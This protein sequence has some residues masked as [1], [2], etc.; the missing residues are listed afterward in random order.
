L[1][2]II[3]LTRLAAKDKPKIMREADICRELR[4]PNI[5]LLEETFID[6]KARLG[7]SRDV[8]DSLC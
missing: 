4:H 3:D 2:Q 8:A 7:D 5:V 6:A 1:A